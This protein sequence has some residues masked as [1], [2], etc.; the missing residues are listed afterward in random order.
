MLTCNA[1]GDK[2]P[3]LFIHKFNTP[4]ILKGI[5]R[6]SPPVYYYW[7]KNAWMQFNIGSVN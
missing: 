1:N 3:P 5:S 4:R 7:S 2:L 6:A